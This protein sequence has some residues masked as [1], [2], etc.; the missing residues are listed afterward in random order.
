MKNA[1][2]SR[3]R[4]GAFHL[5][6]K[7]GELRANG[8][9]DGEVAVVLAEQPFRL[10]LMMVE[11]D[12]AIVTRE[13][14]Q[15]KFWPNDTVV[16]FD[17]SINAAIR[18]LRRALNDSADEPKYIA[19]VAR[20]GYRLMV[21]VEHV[22]DD[23]SSEFAVRQARVDAIS[24]SAPANNVQAYEA[25]CLVGKKVSHYRVLEVIGGGGMGLVYKAEDLKLGRQVALKFL[26]EE[27]AWDPTTL[28]RFER[29][30][31]TASS[32]DHPNICTIYEV[33]EHEEQPFLVMQL[34]NG[35]TLRDHLANI[36]AGHTILPT[37][38]VLEFAIQITAGLQ[39]AHEKGIIHRDIKP[40]NIFVTNA[41]QIK[42][43]DF[44]LAKLVHT[45]KECGSDTVQLDS[46]NGGTSLSTSLPDATL[47]RMG[48]AMGT[49][50]YMSPEQVRGENLDGR[51]DL[52]SFGLVLYEMATGRRAFTGD[53]AA[54]VRDAIVSQSPVPVRELN[55]SLP[56]KL[57]T[58][59][60]RTM[61]KDRERRYESAADLGADLLSIKLEGEWA[62]AAPA[63]AA[64]ADGAALPAV[65]P[66]TSRKVEAEVPPHRAITILAAIL[67]IALVAS[68][69]WLLYTKLHPTKIRSP[70][71]Q[72]SIERLTTDGKTTGSVNIS[73]D[74]K[75][76]VYE[77]ERDDKHSLWLRQVATSSSVKLVPDSDDTYFGTTFSPDGNYIYFVKVSSQAV[78]D[79]KLYKV[80]TLGGTPQE[81]LSNIGS[82][83]TFSPD[84][85]QFAFIREGS[86]QGPTSQLVTANIDGSD[87]HPL[88]AVTP[89]LTYFERSGP[90]WSPDGKRIAVGIILHDEQ[91]FGAGIVMVDFSGRMTPFV[92]RLPG[93]VS[94]LQWL[95]DGS[96]LVFCATATKGGASAASIRM[97][98]QIWFVSYPEGEVSHITNDL[99]SYGDVGLGVTA[100]GSTLVT[101]QRT[102]TSA[103]WVVS[104]NFQKARQV[105]SGRE[106][107]WHAVGG[108]GG[109]IAYT[110]SPTGTRSVWIADRNGANPMQLTPE[111]DI[112][113]AFSFS[114]DG[115]S[116]AYCLAPKSTY[117]NDVWLINVDGSNARQVTHTGSI[118]GVWFSPDGEWIYYMHRSEGSMRLFKIASTGGE[119]IQVSDLEMSGESLSP[120]GNRMLLRYFDKKASQWRFG[121]IS[122]RDGK[123]LHVIDRPF[124]TYLPL[125][126]YVPEWLNESTVF[127][128]ATHNGVSNLWKAPLDGG[129]PVQLTHFTSD[130]I[131]NSELADDGAMIMARG[132][133]E[134]DA[135]LIRNFH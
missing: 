71:Q 113:G 4:F 106:D 67:S 115:R 39:A 51:T 12:G 10:L 63:P 66:E 96:G 92:R 73:P 116:I 38:K 18:K 62:H 9:A 44:G 65:P 124:S 29:E 93:I 41:G 79:G 22:V 107:G 76:V 108:A 126:H 59:I 111:G 123:L 131:W 118:V 77:A 135:I 57:V 84:G 3:V 49:A 15:R 132:K 37:G 85:K 56:E 74:G 55:P 21:P 102:L 64:Q 91:G 53:T 54:I 1:M 34:L 87:Q 28:Q 24:P 5:D 48:V 88:Y 11:R 31:R 133:L 70:L 46:N 68:L 25:G 61:E 127:F 81:I 129:P 105:T 75:Y 134:S 6:V 8:G 95:N 60:D 99:N 20:R 50:A 94:R 42:I 117:K 17:H 104:D 82:P 7:A 35:E 83:V 100:D 78:S 45:A 98:E 27:L 72:M 80:P 125:S 69:G 119:P 103:V 110:S 86:P 40:A 109:K 90:S 112:G 23:D 128:P 58:T 114:P 33:D 26:P 47:T 121:I 2:P 101:V 89:P 97:G 19:T 52:F 13:E 36:A 16:E 32:L 14:I 30:A 130:L 120:D 43:L 122:T